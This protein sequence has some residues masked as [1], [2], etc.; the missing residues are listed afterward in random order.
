M[1]R[2][3]HLMKKIFLCFLLGPFSWL[4]PLVTIIH[5]TFAAGTKWSNPGG[6]FFEAVKKEASLRG[7]KTISYNWSGELSLEARMRAAHGLAA[8]LLSYPETTE[9]IVIGHSHG[10]NVISLASELIN[11]TFSSNY[12]LKNN[13]KTI[14]R[15]LLFYKAPDCKKN[16]LTLKRALGATKSTIIDLKKRMFPTKSS[17]YKKNHVITTAFFLGTPVTEN[18]HKHNMQVIK[19]IISLYSLGDYVQTLV[20]ERTFMPQENVINIK[21]TLNNYNPR[22]EEIHARAIGK[23][24]LALHDARFLK[25]GTIAF[26]DNKMP[27]FTPAETKQLRQRPYPLTDYHALPQYRKKHF[28]KQAPAYS[29]QTHQAP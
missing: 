1:A 22:H 8:L 16:V 23:G 3:A 27:F 17:Y 5:G 12:E 11:A 13:I 2:Y 18:A 20:G 15:D 4:N 21:V 25:D 26:N 14:T 6:D 28:Q 7:H 10:G 9:H 19:R 24:L 29:L